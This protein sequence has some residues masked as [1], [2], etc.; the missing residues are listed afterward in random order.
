MDGVIE[1]DQGL[2]VRHMLLRLIGGQAAASEDAWCQTW[3]VVSRNVPGPRIALTCATRMP[4]DA[5]GAPKSASSSAAAIA[6]VRFASVRL[7]RLSTRENFET[8]ELA[9]L[10][11]RH[12]DDAPAIAVDARAADPGDDD[13]AGIVSR[14]NLAWREGLE[15]EAAHLMC[16]LDIGRIA[17]IAVGRTDAQDRRR[18][19]RRDRLVGLNAQRRRAIRSGFPPRSRKPPS[20][21]VPRWPR[22]SHDDFIE[23]RA[24]KI[25]IAELHDLPAALR[26]NRLP[27]HCRPPEVRPR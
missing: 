11:E 17:M 21:S 7:R 20:P 9:L 13:I 23:S 25:G 10:A 26:P 3:M 27:R 6:I 24:D 16:E 12:L 4:S 19:D 8:V 5:C 2:V 14:P 22:N 18:A 1:Q 15:P